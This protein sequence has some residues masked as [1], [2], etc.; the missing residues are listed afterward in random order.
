[1]KEGERKEE[2]G[3]EEG[4]KKEERGRREEG[5]L[6]LSSL[7]IFVTISRELELGQATFQRPT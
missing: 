2:G 6:H 3:V 4:G 5:P 1:M 7:H